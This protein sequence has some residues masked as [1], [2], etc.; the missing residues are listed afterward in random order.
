MAD[1]VDNS[2]RQVVRTDLFASIEERY[3][4][5]SETTLRVAE[6]NDNNERPLE[7]DPTLVTSLANVLSMPTKDDYPLW[8]IRCKV[9]IFATISDSLTLSFV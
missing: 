9:S 8:R 2:H 1:T 7:S 4:S 5:E 6:G 3:G